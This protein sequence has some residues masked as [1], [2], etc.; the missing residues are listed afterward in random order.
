MTID[1]RDF[2]KTFLAGLGILAAKN[3]LVAAFVGLHEKK[4]IKKNKTLNQKIILMPGHDL[5]HRG[6]FGM[7]C[8]DGTKEAL[9]TREI[10]EVIADEMKRAGINVELTRSK[11]SERRSGF[12]YSKKL[13]DFVKK[14]E[15][16]IINIRKK[17]S[18]TPLSKS[19]YYQYFFGSALY[20]QT[21]ADVLLPIHIQSSDVKVSRMNCRSRK[22]RKGYLTV[23]QAIKLA[24]QE[25]FDLNVIEDIFSHYKDRNNH[26]N[27]INF[28][29]SGLFTLLPKE[30]SLNEA[31]NHIAFQKVLYDNVSDLGLDYSN[32]PRFGAECCFIGKSLQNVFLNGH[33]NPNALSLI[34]E[35]GY[36]TNPSDYHKLKDKS[37]Q[38]KIA[39]MLITSL[40]QHYEDI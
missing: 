28:N 32:E 15:R 30:M 24:K 33:K 18:T 12:D 36:G 25:N 23:N 37:H 5:Y 17:I 31:T 13:E 40:K 6:K 29:Y 38:K 20:A 16:K 11:A 19:N 2:L 4:V 7:A 10:S 14:N 8:L 39:K 26:R 9:L 27:Y 34:L 1:R 3:P 21:H 22:T 35:C